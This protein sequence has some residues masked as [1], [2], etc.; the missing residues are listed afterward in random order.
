MTREGRTGYLSGH[1]Y[2]G[3]RYLATQITR[4]EIQLPHV[5][6]KGSRL[7]FQLSDLTV[8]HGACGR[9]AAWGVFLEVG[10]GLEA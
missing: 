2:L 10:L 4:T 5:H 8:I 1:V 9:K 3:P 6:C 7:M